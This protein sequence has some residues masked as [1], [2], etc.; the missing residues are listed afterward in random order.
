[1]YITLDLVPRPSTWL[2]LTS[3]PQCTM[4]PHL[5][6]LKD[7]LHAALLEFLGTTLF[8]FVG[9]G[10]IQAASAENINNP[11]AASAVVQVLY[12]STCMGFSLLV[13]AWLFYRVTGAVF[14]PNI[15][16]A[17]L[18]VGA[19]KPERFVLYCIAQLAGAVAASGLLMALTPGELASK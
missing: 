13:S 18:L 10:G 4:S 1:M 11:A 3:S 12:I 7:D 19:M 5:S 14:N 2:I 8:L 16:L 6:G 9:L 17:L 15:S